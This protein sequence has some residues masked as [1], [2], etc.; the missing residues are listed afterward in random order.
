MAIRNSEQPIEFCG[1]VTDAARCDY[2]YGKLGKGN[3]IPTTWQ[4]ALISRI[5]P[6]PAIIP[7]GKAFLS[8][9]NGREIP[10]RLRFRGEASTKL[11]TTR[12]QMSWRIDE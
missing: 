12:N 3:A 1:M 2:R 5:L 7:V 11:G 9:I 10:D 6:I 4:F 8:P